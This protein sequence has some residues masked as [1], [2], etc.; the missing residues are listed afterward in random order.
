MQKLYAVST[1]AILALALVAM[2]TIQTPTTNAVEAK[3]P[4]KECH[5]VKVQIKVSGV[6]E[7]QTVV[8]T[9]Q[10]GQSA[11]TKT[12][13]VEANETSITLP[14]NFNKISPCPALGTSFFGNVNG[15][16]FTGNLSS[17]KKPN[18]VK[19]SL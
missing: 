14:I 7:N 13:T 2:A 4:T 17:L 6:K 18:V 1:I 19:V 10:I 16:G 11:K 3:K 5:N 8:G 12:G 15:T 9:V